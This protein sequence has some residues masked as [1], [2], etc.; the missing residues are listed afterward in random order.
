MASINLITILGP[1]ATG[2]TR[3]AAEL[4]FHLKTDIIS[5]DSRQVYRG[6]NLGTGKDYQDYKVQNTQ[7]K[8]HLLDIVD[9][10]Y[11][12]NVYEYQRDF[13]NAFNLIRSENKIPVLC[14]GTGM[15]IEAVLSGYKLIKV[16][17]N[18]ALRKELEG[19]EIPELV[20][21]LRSYKTPHNTTDSLNQKRLIR[22]IEIEEYYLRHPETGSGY[23][24]IFPFIVGVLV[25]RDARRRQITQRLEQRLKRGM[26]EEVRALIETGVGIDSLIYYGLEYK[27]IAQHITGELTYDQM[28]SKLETAIHQFAKRQ[29]TW[30][31]GMEKRGFEIFWVDGLLPMEE[32]SGLILNQMRTK[33]KKLV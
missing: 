3:L 17:E 33:Y 26:V 2:K 22:A 7:L 6:M 12:Y 32:K 14:G 31:R 24:D 25:D 18:P 27:F 28:F 13:L 4:A 19:R 21:K 10:G 8:V 20:K 1:T 16:P 5:A 15:Y 23:P 11:R 30:F 9:A 29:M